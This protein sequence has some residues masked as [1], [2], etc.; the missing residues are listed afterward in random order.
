MIESSAVSFRPTRSLKVSGALGALPL[1]AIVGKKPV[2]KH[3]CQ[4]HRWRQSR[5][6]RTCTRCG[7]VEDKQP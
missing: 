5:W 4:K 3:L 2:S 1:G 7:L 6:S